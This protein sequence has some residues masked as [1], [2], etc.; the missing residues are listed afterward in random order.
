MMESSEPD[1]GTL[2]TVT[3][4][5]IDYF[6]QF[7]LKEYENISQAH[8]K[9]NEVLSTFYRYFLLI[10][11]IPITAVGIALINLSDGEVSADGRFL[12]YAI[13]GVSTI[14][15][16]VVGAAVIAYIEGL[17]LDAILYARVV[18]SIR[19]YFFKL[20]GAVKFGP[21]VLPTKRDMPAY[22]GFGA[23]FIIYFA[24]AIMNAAYF[25]SGVLVL[26]LD[27]SIMLVDTEITC[28]QTWITVISAA[29]MLCSQAYI[30][31]WLLRGKVNKGF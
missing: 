6:T 12:A 18:N 11:A 27:H 13:F 29:I 21:P 20:P 25:G 3:E 26:S 4:G 15:L 24:C 14:L 30:R 22:N 10:A 28:S 16:S 9:T 5:E 2:D 7:Q 23:G 8:F 17:R 31:H 19:S 1:G